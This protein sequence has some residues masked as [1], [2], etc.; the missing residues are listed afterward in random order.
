MTVAAKSGQFA[1]AKRERVSSSE[2]TEEIWA[3]E[4]CEG[5]QSPGSEAEVPYPYND[6]G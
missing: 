5:F 2:K 4:N 1:R 6:R 3:R